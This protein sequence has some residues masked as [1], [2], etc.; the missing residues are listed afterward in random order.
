MK[1]FKHFT[2][3]HRGRSV[4]YLL[5]ELG[6][7]GPFFYYSI[8]EMCAEKLDR[9]LDAKLTQDDCTFNFHR[10]VVC[11]TTRARPTT[12]VRALDAGATCGLW[13]YTLD[14]EQIKISMPIILELLEFDLK[15]SRSSTVKT[16]PSYRLDQNRIDKSSSSDRSESENK[17]TTTVVEINTGKE[18]G[19]VKNLSATQSF[20]NRFKEHGQTIL[21]IMDQYQ[22]F[23]LKKYTGKIVEFYGSPK[24][25]LDAINTLSKQRGFPKEDHEQKVYVS[26]SILNQMGVTENRRGANE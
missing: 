19:S 9:K 2:D 15:R 23:G 11:S 6:Y 7:F 20:D 1:W 12:V 25:F 13:T 14:R 18:L 24:N 26:K 22:F 4:Q 17:E 10:R 8:F 5:D 3:N 16:G 21:Q